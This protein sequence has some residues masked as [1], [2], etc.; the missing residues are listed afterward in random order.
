MY[1]QFVF[2]FFYRRVSIHFYVC[3]FCDLNSLQTPSKN[4]LQLINALAVPQNPKFVHKSYCSSGSTNCP[5]ALVVWE[6]NKLTQ[7]NVR[8]VGN[9]RSV[10][11][12]F[13]RLIFTTYALF[14][15]V[16]HITTNVNKINELSILLLK[17]VAPS[18]PL[19]FSLIDH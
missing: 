5:R 2:D 15:Y 18:S 12:Q 10:C 8:F 19:I 4:L 7:T 16:T 1:A 6:V 9:M 11:T 3:T 14:L 13:N 17:F